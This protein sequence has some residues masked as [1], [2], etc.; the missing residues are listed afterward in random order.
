MFKPRGW[1]TFPIDARQ[2]HYLFSH[3]YIDYPDIPSSCI[4]DKNKSDGLARYVME[5]P[6]GAS[7]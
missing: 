7:T 4:A 3:G 5:N 6:L 1:K 2:V